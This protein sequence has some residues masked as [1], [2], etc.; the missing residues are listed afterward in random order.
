MTRHRHCTVPARA[1]TTL[2]AMLAACTPLAL[3]ACMATPERGAMSEFVVVRHAEKAS[4]GSRDPALNAQGAARAQ[5]LAQRLRHAP[6]V[7][8]YATPYQRTRQTAQPTA[9]AHGLQVSTYN[10]DLPPAELVAQLRR[11]HPQGTV[12]VVGH[13]NTAPQIAAQLCGC[14]VAPLADD[15]YGDL[16]RITLHPQQP[17]ALSHERF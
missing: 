11:A 12:M 1:W 7:G 10:A 9:H 16:Y 13:S 6:V 8:A 4:D 3:A 15:A 5:A 17:A 2:R 14:T